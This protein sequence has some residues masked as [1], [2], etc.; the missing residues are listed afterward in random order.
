MALSSLPIVI[1]YSARC[2]FVFHASLHFTDSSGI[3][4][5]SSKGLAFV[6]DGFRDE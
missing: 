5:P 2:V 4:L 3:Q 1:L 6:F